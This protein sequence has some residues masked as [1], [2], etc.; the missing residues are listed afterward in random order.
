MTDALVEISSN[1]NTNTVDVIFPMWPLLM[2]LNPALGKYILLPALKYQ[3]T[4]QYPNKYSVHDM[5]AHFP[6][7]IGHNDGRDEAM[8]VEGELRG[9]EG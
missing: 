4:G 8:P 1:G 6:K 7:A 3:A 2:Y 5:G 9:A